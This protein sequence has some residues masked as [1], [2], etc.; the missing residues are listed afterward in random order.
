MLEEVKHLVRMGASVIRLHEKSKRPVGDDWSSKPRLTLSQLQAQYRDGEN[1]GIRLG[2]P[3][4]I[5][6]M[7]LHAVDL[8]IRDDEQ[9]DDALN[10]FER[11]FKGVDV[12]SLPCV[13]SG[14][15]GASRHFYFVTDKP[16]P[17]KKLAKSKGNVFGAD[18]KW[19]KAWEIELFGTG[20][21]VVAPPSIHPVTIC[22][23]TW[24]KKVNAVDGF[25]HIDADLI[26]ELVNPE[27]EGDYEPVEPIDVSYD[28]VREWLDGIDAEK[29]C[30]DR[31]GWIRLGMALSYNFHKSPEA[32]EVWDDFSRR[33]PKYDETDLLRNWDSFK[34]RTNRPVTLRSVIKDYNE[35][36]RDAEFRALPGEFEDLEPEFTTSADDFDDLIEPEITATADDFEDLAV[37]MPARRKTPK[38]DVPQ[39]LLEVPGEL[40]NVVEFYSATAMK[41]QPQFAVQTAL[42][43]GSLILGRV[44]KTDYDNYSSLYF[45]NIGP[46]ASGKEHANRVIDKLL[47]ACSLSHLM[48]PKSYTS[49]SGVIS[50]LMEKPK[51]ITVVDELGRFLSSVREAK[52]SLKQETQ[53]AL[54]EVFGRLDGTARSV[55]Y[56]THGKTKEQIEQDNNRFVVRPALTLLAMTTPDTLFK[57]LGGMDVKDGFLNRF[58]I[59][60]SPLG[61]QLSREDAP[62]ADIPKSLM[63]WARVTATAHGGE[64]DDDLRMISDPKFIPVPREVPFSRECKPILRQMEERVI[65]EMNRLDEHSMAELYGRTREIAMRLSLIVA[66]SCNSRTVKPEHLEW[67]RDYVFHYHRAMAAR[68]VTSLG[69]SEDEA[70]AED[71]FAFLKKRGSEGATSN[72]IANFVRAFRKLDP[73]KERPNLLLRVQ[74]DFGVK[75]TEPD[76]KGQKIKRYFAPKK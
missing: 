43:F 48:G 31:D 17:S 27:G 39:R 30:D 71:V 63:D 35:N 75:H 24:I 16:F 56:S 58:L 22:R 64:E 54:M 36:K 10:K 44:W 2:K 51:H 9:E 11:L 53:T 23:Y 19:H 34:H 15:G 65:D 33:S 37:R 74:A 57:A 28:E 3:S 13:L 72:Q 69:K 18:K 14:S 76:G 1:L 60:E 42:A 70:I 47:E 8:D 68:F 61:R 7:F 62:R 73:E 12:W 25:P 5:D 50:T 45:L 49:E 6:G 41:D 26:E 38:L 21:Q 4:E 40:Q 66:V 20:K 32:L 29:W 55:G 52:G 46:T 59:V 67:A